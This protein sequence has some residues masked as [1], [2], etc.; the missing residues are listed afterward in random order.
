[1]TPLIIVLVTTA[2]WFVV[3]VI[4]VTTQ[5]TS[6]AVSLGTF[7]L[8][9]SLYNFLQ[10]AKRFVGK[11][12]SLT[13]TTNTVATSLAKHGYTTNVAKTIARAILLSSNAGAHLWNFCI[14]L[15][16][17]QAEKFSIFPWTY[18]GYA[19]LVVASLKIISAM[20]EY[21]KIE[22]GDEIVVTEQPMLRY[23]ANKTAL[24]IT[25][26]YLGY[27]ILSWVLG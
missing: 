18:L 25:T 6:P 22:K 11:T 14:V 16:L 3:P 19:A 12:I 4:I 27:A 21:I 17:V 9:W 20:Y 1:M 26:T 7:L 24:L 23:V 5:A 2:L 10:P 8:V 13:E 15:T